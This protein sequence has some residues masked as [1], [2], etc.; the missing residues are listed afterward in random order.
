M[1]PGEPGD[2]CVVSRRCRWPRLPALPWRVS[3]RGQKHEGPASLRGPDS[4]SGCLSSLSATRDAAPTPHCIGLAIASTR[5]PWVTGAWAAWAAGV[6]HDRPTARIGLTLP[7]GGVQAIPEGPPWLRC[8]FVGNK[9]PG[10]GRVS[11]VHAVLRTM[12]LACRKW[13]SAVNLTHR[14][15]S[16]QPTVWRLSQPHRRY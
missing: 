15:F 2:G 6:F 7:A 16:K 12:R 10:R 3:R 11:V 9:K 13:H 14:A 8:Q 4:P 5:P 1:R